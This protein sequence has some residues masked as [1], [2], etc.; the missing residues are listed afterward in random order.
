MKDHYYSI[1]TSHYKDISKTPYLTQRKEVIS[2]LSQVSNFDGVMLVIYYRSQMPVTTS[3]GP[4]LQN[5]YIQC[6]YLAHMT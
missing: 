3:R 4:R 1:N 6:S 2:T 5:S